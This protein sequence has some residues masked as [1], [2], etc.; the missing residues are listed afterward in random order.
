MCTIM[1]RSRDC[2]MGKLNHMTPPGVACDDC[3]SA[4]PSDFRGHVYWTREVAMWRMSSVVK[5]NRL[6]KGQIKDLCREDDIRYK[7]EV[8]Q[9]LADKVRKINAMCEAEADK[10][11]KRNFSPELDSQSSKRQDTTEVP[12]TGNNYIPDGTHGEQHHTVT[13][14]YE[15]KQTKRVHRH[16]L[17]KTHPQYGKNPP[18]LPSA[19]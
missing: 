1:D 13:K 10:G 7:E 11:R 18:G 3:K 15:T 12:T 4:E 9:R 8:E 6:S 2:Q 17:E 19:Q 16:V 5:T 14:L